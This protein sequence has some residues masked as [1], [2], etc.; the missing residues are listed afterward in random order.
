MT[1]KFKTIK[2]DDLGKCKFDSPLKHT[3]NM[4]VT[5]E[6]VI[7]DT[8]ATDLQ[9][10]IEKNDLQFFELAGARE[11]IFFQ[12][13][14]T[15]VAIVTCGGLCPGI[16]DVIRAITFCAIKQYKVN[17]VLGL[18][19]GYEGL[20]AKFYHTPMELNTENTDE[21][22]EKG[23]TILGS[24][25]G[26]QPN[27]EIVKTLRH[28]KID[29]L[30]TIGGDGTQ[31]AAAEICEEIKK[32]NLN[33]S[34]IG[35]P[36]TIDNDI[37]CLERSFGFD[38]AIDASWQVI[39]SAHAEAKG[40]K[41]GIGL[42]KLMGRDSGWI[43]SLSALANSNVNFCL[44]PEVDF[45]LEGQ[46][47]FLKHLKSRLIRSEHA[48]I[49]VAEGAGQKLMQR[50]GKTDKS[51][52]ERLADIG[53]FLNDAIDKY[54]KKEKME[55][56]VKYFD[57]SYLIRSIPA[58]AGDS[59]YCL[60]LGYNAVHA[61]MCGKTN[62]IIGLHTERIVHFPM[63]LIGKRKYVNPEKWLWKTVLQTTGQPKDM[64]N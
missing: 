34:V 9:P 40:Y 17:K 59:A 47:G 56:N 33:I 3:N 1:N 7:A 23:G 32:Q 5:D 51:G 39:N 61:G 20:V 44:I 12:P 30:F 45:D 52:N 26:Q 37:N 27:E 60:R 29:I 8:Y 16:N 63:S 36:K 49:A 46:N 22:H 50:T 55:V 4:F 64:L 48:V 54:F 25:R 19:Y 6:G 35:I 62:I 2:V 18:K 21:I 42:V 38:S 24:S 13:E 10:Q 57:P 43:T 58:N 41:N 31:R 15:N 11:K 28:Y 53:V 14:K